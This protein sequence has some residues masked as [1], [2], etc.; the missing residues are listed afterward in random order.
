MHLYTLQNLIV[1][2]RRKG[3]VERHSHALIARMHV[4]V[5]IGVL[6]RNAVAIHVGCFRLASIGLEHAHRSGIAHVVH[7]IIRILQLCLSN[8]AHRIRRQK[9][10][11]HVVHHTHGLSLGRARHAR[12][13]YVVALGEQ[14]TVANERRTV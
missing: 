11:I 4:L 6:A 13:R 2:R 1:L 10:R 9:L 7:G 14:H 8:L 3:F 5:G 12:L